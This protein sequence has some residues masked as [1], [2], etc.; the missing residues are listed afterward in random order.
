MNVLLLVQIYNYFWSRKDPLIHIQESHFDLF[1]IYKEAILHNLRKSGIVGHLKIRS[2][3]KQKKF[4]ISPYCSKNTFCGL[5]I[6]EVLINSG[7]IM[8]FLHDFVMHCE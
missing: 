6:R 7:N 5:F 4:S 2:E 3:P 1:I 8:D